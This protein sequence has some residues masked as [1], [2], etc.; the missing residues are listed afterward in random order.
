[1]SFDVDRVRESEF[2]WA[3]RGEAVYLNNAS[4]GPLPERALRALREFD[5]RRAAPYRLSD[6]LQFATLAR[7]REL[8]AR[9]ISAE[10]GE[11]GLA[12][13]TSYGINL[14]AFSLPLGAGDVVLTPD[15]EFPANVYP[16]M[17]LAR[18]RGVIY[19]RIPTCDGA[20]DEEALR[21]ELEDPSVRAVSVSWVGFASG[22]TVDLEAIGRACRARGAYF[23]VDAIQGLGPLTLDVRACH[24]DILA[25]GAQK[26][27]LS[28]WGTGFVYVRRELLGEL[29][30]NVVSWMA[31][32]GSD[33]FRRLVDYDLTW[34]DD[35]RRFEFITLPFQDFAGMNASLELIHELGPAAIAHQV[36]SLADVIVLWAASQRDVELVTPSLP[37]HRAGIVSLR[38]PNAGRVSAALKEAGVSHSLREGAIRLSPHF[39]NTRE[40]IRRTLRVIESALEP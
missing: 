16:W 31:V 29:E 10:V 8:I 15:R 27:L 30:P 3:A 36:A 5:E 6:E 9:L 25:C 22:Y 18:R 38:M 20:V 33:D 37:R 24:I 34:R 12:V 35:A 19:R 17:E 39:Y 40:E 26:W 13:N 7:G 32:K 23:V 11:I 2:P 28:P 14:A 4:T 1:V 21:R